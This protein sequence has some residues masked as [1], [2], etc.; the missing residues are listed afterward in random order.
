MNDLLDKKWLVNTET[1][2]LF[3]DNGLFHSQMG[4]EP[5]KPTEEEIVEGRAKRVVPTIVPAE[6]SA[7][8][9][10]EEDTEFTPEELAAAGLTPTETVL[11]VNEA[12]A[13]PVEVP[14]APAPKKRT[15]R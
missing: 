8:A 14:A 9:D 10:E 12:T 6:Q 1:G 11:T 4:L 7:P 15:R 13:D 5:Y 3:I 2:L